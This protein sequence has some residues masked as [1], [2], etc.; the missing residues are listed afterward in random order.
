MKAY[1]PQSGIQILY[2]K[3][4]DV[5]PLIYIETQKKLQNELKE[6]AAMKKAGKQAGNLCYCLLPASNNEE[7]TISVFYYNAYI[8]SNLS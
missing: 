1:A 7:I 5:Q 2:F 6:R 4:Q 3:S 8:K